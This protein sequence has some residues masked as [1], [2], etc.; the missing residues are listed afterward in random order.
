M[1]PRTTTSM[2]QTASRAWLTLAGLSLLLPVGD[3][4]GLWLPLHLTL[5]GAASVAIAGAMQNFSAALTATG[6]APTPWVW[7]QFVSMNA[8]VAALALGRPLDH[9]ALVAAGGTAFIVSAILLLWFVR[10]AWRAALNKRHRL[11]IR[12]Y[13]FSVA[14]VIVGGA[15][16]A[17][18]GSGT[19][20]GVTAYAGL[21][22][23]HMTLN[24]LGWVSTTIVGT[25]VTLLPT[26]MR[27]RMPTA[28]GAWAAGLLATGVG[29]LALGVA[30]STTAVAALGGLTEM[31]G[32]LG[33]AWL[34]YT[35]ARTAKPRPAPLA[36]LHL[37][38]GVAWFTIGSVALAFSALRGVS[39]FDGF[40]GDFLAIFVVGW[41]VQVLL[42]A[43][44]YLL[45]M[46]RRG[47]PDVRRGWLVAIESGAWL[48]LGAFNAGILLIVARAAGWLGPSFGSVGVWLALGAGALALTKAWSFPLLA[49]AGLSSRRGQVVWSRAEAPRRTGG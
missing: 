22:H 4:L 42:G 47:D 28:H 29:M 31:A 8:G 5:A 21:L 23:A 49:R 36:A 17:L 45:P 3:R 7:V 46:G 9:P 11:P 25:M 15:F 41:I 2:Y 37:V 26:T 34:V 24:V 44:S 12:I 40:H 38:A 39:G 14:C 27:V 30:T 35:I 48:Q 43:W 6:S 20:H 16:G 1:G 33:V 32:A 10:R 13:S 19:V 18:I